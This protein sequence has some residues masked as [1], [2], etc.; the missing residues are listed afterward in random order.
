MG[1]LRGCSRAGP[2]PQAGGRGLLIWGPGSFCDGVKPRG[3][4]IW[5]H[6]LLICGVDRL[7]E[8]WCFSKAFPYEEGETSFPEVCHEEII[9]PQLLKGNRSG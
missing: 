9:L 6:G 3:C 7:A 1:L 8:C 2:I 5:I 4:F